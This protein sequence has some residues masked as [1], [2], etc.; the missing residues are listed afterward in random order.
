[1][2]VSKPAAESSWSLIEVMAVVVLDDELLNFATAPAA[3]SQRE[4]RE[5]HFGT[6]KESIS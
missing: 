5:R 6:K 2:T 1:M 3:R 4:Q